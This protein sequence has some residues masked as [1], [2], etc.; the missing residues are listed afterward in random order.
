MAATVAPRRITALEPD[1]A[2]PGTVR[3]LVDGRLFCTVGAEAVGQTGLRIGD[4]WNEAQAARVGPAADAQAA[5]RALLR[6]LERRS[7]AIGDLRKKLL[8][9]GHPPEAV[10][11]AIE[12]GIDT[13]LLND[14][15]FATQFVASRAARGR[16]PARLRRDLRL[17]GVAPSL[18][19]SA[20][21]AQ[22]PEPADSL[23]LARDLARRRA[24]Q[25]AGLPR[26]VRVRR[27]VAFLARRGFSGSRVMALVRE[28]V[29]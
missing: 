3:V 10:A 16:G 26:E 15:A 19:E 21:Q 28:A 6:S 20:L 17:L 27:L 25:L 8:Q 1:P 5:W 13:G 12:R 29:G 11:A 4:A 24:K 18:V 2:D 14:A 22:W 23:E 7:F 9:K